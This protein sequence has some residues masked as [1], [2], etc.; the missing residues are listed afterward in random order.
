MKAALILWLDSDVGN[1]TRRDVGVFRTNYVIHQF[2]GN[3]LPPVLEM[4]S[5]I[6]VDF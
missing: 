6:G 3:G 5:K 4:A 1:D 2:E